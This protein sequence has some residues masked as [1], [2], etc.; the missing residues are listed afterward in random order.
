MDLASSMDEN[1]I[2]ECVG[3]EAL[4]SVLPAVKNIYIA[5]FTVT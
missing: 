4:P 1:I 5:I 3:Y 2:D